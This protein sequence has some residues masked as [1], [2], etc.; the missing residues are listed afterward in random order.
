MFCH[1]YRIFSIKR[2]LSFKRPSPINAPSKTIFFLYTPLSFKRPPRKQK[3]FYKRP[4]STVERGRLLECEA[5][6]ILEELEIQKRVDYEQCVRNRYRESNK[7]IFVITTLV[8][9]VK[10]SSPTQAVK[11]QDS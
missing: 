6:N 4:S 5:E 2:P 11:I 9:K 10:Y 8:M 7:F 1:I 3:T